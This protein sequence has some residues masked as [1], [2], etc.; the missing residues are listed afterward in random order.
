[1]VSTPIS[2]NAGARPV[3]TSE[4][5]TLNDQISN[6]NRKFNGLFSSRR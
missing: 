4:D 1:M 2:G 3:A 6:L 5:Q